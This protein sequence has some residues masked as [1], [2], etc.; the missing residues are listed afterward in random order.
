ML[1]EVIT[2]FIATLATFLAGG[3]KPEAA[4]RAAAVNAASVVSQVDTQG[5]LLSAAALTERVAAQA[6]LLPV[7]LWH[8]TAP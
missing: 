3:R 6:A 8:W 5:G 7:T 2:A 1:Y 4:L